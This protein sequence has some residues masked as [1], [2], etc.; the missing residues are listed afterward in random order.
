VRSRLLAALRGRFER[1]IT[2]IVAG[3]G[4]GKTT[5]LAQAIAENRL[6]PAGEDRWLGCE[7]DDSVAA[8]LGAG[9]CAALE[10]PA[11][12]ADDPES[13]ARAVTVAIA[14]R[15]PL[16]IALVLDDAHEIVPD[17]SG[18]EVV[19]R[20]SDELPTNGHVVV[21][22]RR[23]PP[24]PLARLVARGE[25]V[26]VDE[27][28]MAFSDDELGRFAGLRGVSTDRMAGWG[29]WPALVELVASA[30]APV[31]REF[32]WEE[33]LGTME[34]ERRQ[35]LAVLA[36]VGEADHATLG[37]ALG[38]PV[39]LDELV[40]DLP[41]VLRGADGTS[42]LHALW[43][44]PL[45]DELD[46][47]E[48]RAALERAGRHLRSRDDLS[49][50]FTLLARAESWTAVRDLVR[51][52]SA[53]THQ[54]TPLGVLEAWQAHL[55]DEV[56]STPE[57]QL[58][59]ALVAK[60]READPAS[61]LPAFEN[62]RRVFA[63]RDDTSGELTCLPHLAQLGF[64]AGDREIVAHALARTFE[65]EERGEREA[66]D[67]ARL[68]RALVAFVGG[69]YD[70]T[71]AELREMRHAR[72]P[73][74]DG[75]VRSLEAEALLVLGDPVAAVSVAE[76]TSQFRPIASD[77]LPGALWLAGRVDDALAVRIEADELPSASRQLQA[78][79]AQRSRFEAFVGRV[80][81]AR[82]YLEQCEQLGPPGSVQVRARVALARAAIAVADDDEPAAA[83]ELAE[84]VAE[85]PY[86]D[87]PAWHA[88]R[89]GLALTYVLVPDSRAY[90]DAEKLG[91]AF[92]TARELARATVAL[93]ERGSARALATLELPEPGVVRSCLPLP[94]AARLAAGIAANREPPVGLL[95]AFGPRARPWLHQ[96]TSAA[97]RPIAAAARRLLA[98]LPATPPFHLDVLVLGPLELRRDGVPIDTPDL[99][100]ERVR[101]VLGYLVLHQGGALRSELAAAL[102]PDHAADA[103][104][105]NLRVTL[106]YLVRGL[107]PDR[108]DGAPSSFVRHDGELLTLAGGDHLAVD[109]W[110]FDSHLAAA[111]AAERD[112]ALSLALEAYGRAVSTWRG[113]LL[114]DVT[115][116]WAESEQERLRVR[117][118]DAATRRG[119]LLL[120]SGET[121][122]P[123][124]LAGAV[125]GLEPWSERAYRLLVSTYL[126][127]GDRSAARRALERCQAMCADL[128]VAPEP[129]TRMLGRR[130]SEPTS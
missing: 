86:D 14:K 46:A 106:S 28:S 66:A 109:V 37:E 80:R 60:T 68:G 23:G 111:R 74:W 84:F 59:G 115:A 105:N 61:A 29:R 107:E 81:E 2:A 47:F 108:L 44:E 65:L 64:W 96:L 88:L 119:E 87:E 92:A 117:Y 102:W 10:V 77:T 73:E 104:A 30:G 93:R 53:L 75:V 6:D 36:A 25:A 124:L 85:H 78:A 118:L 45:A 20:L 128:G 103:A 24:L 99:R 34:P 71:L 120:A 126:E 22:G 116:G 76:V 62:V 13:V 89:R 101:H 11:P 79:W 43:A 113:P 31:A 18:A 91:P 114:P 8:V 82:V 49:G 63:D 56:A 123:E 130:L 58:L 98:D 57:G 70:D 94:W 90:W 52:A 41:L 7:P 54:R 50:A 83:R 69:R 17:S 110:A 51:D 12:A 125:L 33:L 95:D 38:R 39:D 97:P 1:R 72:A 129:E 67:L 5:L 19:A 40:A 16:P 26:R 55:P 9:L 15:A 100:R 3:P 112:G 32:L 127:R 4:F 42:A 27:R 35:A 122:E 48:R 121:H 21:A